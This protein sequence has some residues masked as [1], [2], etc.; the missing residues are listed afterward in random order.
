M[1]TSPSRI[2]ELY[3]RVVT[4]AP[5]APMRWPSTSPARA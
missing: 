5:T 2:A 3:R 4:V 1:V